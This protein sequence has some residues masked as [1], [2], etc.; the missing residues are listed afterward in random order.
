MKLTVS[1][2]QNVEVEPIEIIE[3]MIKTIKSNPDSYFMIKDDQ[4]FHVYIS[5]SGPHETEK[6]VPISL[7]KYNYIKALEIV[8]DYLK[9]EKF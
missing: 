7:E 2:T 9:S 3:K 4:P 8:R 1:A 6:F 5:Y